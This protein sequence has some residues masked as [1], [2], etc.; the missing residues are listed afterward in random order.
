[1]K[2]NSNWLFVCVVVLFGLAFLMPARAEA[3]QID[4]H[5]TDL[6]Y[7]LNE[8]GTP[9][10]ILI[11]E[12][13]FTNNTDRYINY[14][15]EITLT[16]TITSTKGYTDTVKGTFRDFEK[17]IEPYGD[18]NHRFR[19]RNADTIWPIDSYN[20]KRGYTRWK[21]SGAAG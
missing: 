2:K 6:Y 11:I 19:I 15:Y 20:V 14:I 13:Y 4:W 7:E 3:A 10:N 21:H 1:M 16:A 8:D 12:G 5:T 9:E 18:S 17:M